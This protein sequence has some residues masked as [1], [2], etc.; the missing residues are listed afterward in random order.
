M[1][2]Y[3][4]AFP[5]NPAIRVSAA[6]VEDVVAAVRRARREGRRVG[7]MA[8]GHGLNAP[9]ED[10]VLITT[11]RMRDVTIDPVARTA[12]L[13]AGVRWAQVIEAAAPY[14]LAPVNGSSARVGAVGYTLGGGSGPLSRAYGFA[15]DHVRRVRLVDGTGLVLEVDADSDPELFWAVRGGKGNFGVVTEIEI[16]LMPVASLYGGSVYYPGEAARDVLHAFGEWS[17]GLPD[18]VATTSVAVL[19]LPPLPELPE[20]LRGQ[21]VVQ[22]RFAHLDGA[23]AGEKVLAGMRSVAGTLLDTVQEMPY[24]SVDS[25]HQDPPEPMPFWDGGAGLA[26]FPAEA[27]DALLDLVGSGRDVPVPL[28]EVRLQGGAMARPPAVPNAVTGRDAA[29]ALSAVG[30]MDG[31]AAHV[32]PGLIDEIVAAV[33]PWRSASDLFNM[34]GPA[35][36][37]RVAALWTEADRARLLAV[38]RRVDPA[39]MFGGAHTIGQTS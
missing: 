32:V 26:G 9:I 11:E 10:G 17:D 3:N 23:D 8:T 38:K 28:V 5:V 12:T 21:L 22:L 37:E 18:R 15:A 29:Y 13:A 39:G 24:T 1:N 33:G 30:L 31:D 2:P 34:I 20:A 36:P 25:I 14:G 7:V 35:A 6:G 27:A 4:L 19:R 16:G